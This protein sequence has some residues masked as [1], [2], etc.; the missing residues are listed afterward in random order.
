[1]GKQN[2]KVSEFKKF[3]ERYPGIA[4]DVRAKEK[5]WQEFFE[6]WYMFGEDDAMWDQY[7]TETKGELITK[8]DDSKKES[9]FVS[10]IMAI[11][12]KVDMN[13]VQK[14]ITTVSGAIANV[15]QI[16]EQFQ[17]IA[18]NNQNQRM[19]GPRNPQNP[20]FYKKD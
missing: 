7:K 11:M 16:L 8:K 2:P 18:P 19:P 5:S 10:Q 1:M 9:D 13:E 12:K 17:G 6:D 3:V 15:Q 20:F 4:K 14:H